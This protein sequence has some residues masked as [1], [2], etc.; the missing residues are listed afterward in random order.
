[1]TSIKIKF[2]DRL[3]KLLK[4]MERDN[5]VAFEMLY[6]I[7][8]KSEYNN[9]FGISNVDIG[10]NFNFLIT[11]S[12]ETY[13]MKVGKFLRHYFKD[14][15]TNEEILKFVNEY[16]KIK[17]GKKQ[18]NINPGERLSV[19]EFQ[20][21]PSDPRSTFLSMVTKT[22][23][24]GH[25]EEVLKFLP[26]LEKDKFGNYYT[27]IGDQKPTTMFTSHLDTADRSQKITSL[28]KSKDQDNNEIIY[29][30]GNS[31][32]GADDKAGVTIMLYMMDKKVNGLYYFFIGE[33]RGGIGSNRLSSEY[34]SFDYLKNIK[35]CVSFDRRKTESVITKQLDRVCCS[36]DFGTALCEEY[37][38]NGINFSLDPT[39]IYTDSASFLDDIPECTNLS[40][41]YENEHTGREL[42]NMTFLIKM[43]EVSVK[44]NW[45]SLPTV[46]KVGLNQEL[47]K[48]HK[49]LID[50]IKR[51]AFGLDIRVV[52]IDDSIYVSIDL[53]EPDI[54]NI[55]DSLVSVQIILD[56]YNISDNLYIHDSFLKIQLR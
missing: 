29:T 49:K 4:I 28:Y 9:D 41:G 31:V 8:P 26:N 47:V 46:R 17:N 13:Y 14:I 40:V 27:I 15:F 30:D 7:E 21:K 44:I 23:P 18:L 55:Y 48:R 56:R 22:Y 12:G 11:I 42:Q 53:D 34:D 33:E 32:L 10:S 25:E 52:G 39:G 35:R 16:N 51:S 38:K 54:D 6:L 37:I 1:M 36:N 2:S 3:T 45:E 5:Y 19:K 50:E 24:H 43:C 20:Y